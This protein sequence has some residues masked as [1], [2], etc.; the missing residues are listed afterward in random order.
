M[1][2]IRLVHRASRVWLRAPGTALAIIALVALGIG[3]MAA[4]FSPLYSLV[5]SPLPLPQPDRLV[6]IGGNIPLFNVY[7]NAFDERG[8]VAS[9][10]TNLSAYAPVT[11]AGAE[12]QFSAASRPKPVSVLA[13]TPEFF[14]MLGVLPRMGASF[15][16][17]PINSPAVVVSD[18][19][20]RAEFARAENVL[21]TVMQLGRKPRTVVGVM[22]EGFDFPGGVD[23]WVLIGSTSYVLT[24]LQTVG[25]LRADLSL[26]QA[27][28]D[29]NAIGYRPAFG[30][31]GQFGGSGPLLQTLQAFLRGDKRDTLWMLWAVSALFLVLACVGAGNLLL[32]QGVRR[33]PEVVV[34]LALGSGRWRLVRQL[35]METLLLV[36]SGALVGVWLSSIAGQWL[37]T[38]IPDLQG[39][40][41]FVP[42]TLALIAALALAVTLA[43]G[44]A[45]ALHATRVELNAALSSRGAHA[46]TLSPRNHHF[47]PREWMAAVQL[48]LALALLIGTGL[49]LRS[50][51][52]YLNRPLGLEPDGVAVFRVQLPRSPGR[53][54]AMARFREEH[55]MPP[56]GRS[57]PVL[58]EL[59]AP[60]LSAERIR[61]AQFLRDAYDGLGRLPDVLAAAVVDPTPFT[62]QA[63]L[64]RHLVYV[65]EA[66]E[67]PGRP[68]VR[69]MYGHVSS[70]GFDLLQ[71][72]LLAGRSFT[73]GDVADEFA[74]EDALGSALP[75]APANAAQRA[76]SGAA[77][78]NEALAQRLWPD[79]NPIGK[80]FRH[81]GG[82]LRVHSVVGVVSNFHWTADS[83]SSGPAVYFPFTG[84]NGS[85]G[86]VVRLRAGAP[87]ERFRADADRVLSELMPGL[88]Q[89]DVRSMR[90]LTEAGLRNTRFASALLAWFSLLGTAVAMLGVYVASALMTAARTHEIGIRIALGATAAEVRWIVVSRTIRLVAVALPAGLLA[91]WALARQLSHLLFL[92]TPTDPAAYAISVVV[93]LAAALLASVLPALRAGATDTVTALKCE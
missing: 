84:D 48:V 32:A 27:A 72:R 4:L 76:L 25:R 60:H 19:L 73:P 91:G 75:G 40:P 12:G 1:E 17:E 70:N 87:I 13:V 39:A 79:E 49:V 31:S 80:R 38:Q 92:V 68:A 64:L 18:R 46:G 28:A 11:D 71:I 69:T 93:L 37:Q 23:A 51:T 85:I 33:R 88:P 16:K 20:W 83:A 57:S 14:E 29:L 52:A 5:L 3:G 9:L 50:I 43:C 66:L 82:T 42:A 30:P 53:A 74:A 65:A 62:P 2:L 36:V 77:I 58:T 26:E 61:N 6:R 54:A 86:F 41:L 90:A 89:L 8:P 44:L 24:G 34:H 55:G 45:P 56:A 22:P 78:V 47:A 7:T 59:L 35:L 15:A 21:G 10:F 81:A 67:A 63:E